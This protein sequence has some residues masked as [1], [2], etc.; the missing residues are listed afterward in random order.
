MDI[1]KKYIVRKAEDFSKRH[2]ASPPLEPYV[3]IC[4]AL[5][6]IQNIYVIVGDEPYLCTSVT[7]AIDL[8]FKSYFALSIDFSKVS[9]HLWTFLYKYVY[10]LTVKGKPISMSGKV[11]SLWASL[12]NMQL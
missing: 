8:C 10:K 12:Q 6:N 1:I 2:P 3:V 9:R 4:G 5:T 7:K 11:D